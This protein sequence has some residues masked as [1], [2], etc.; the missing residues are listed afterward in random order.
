[1][2]FSSDHISGT[3]RAANGIARLAQ[4]RAKDAWQA[5]QECAQQNP[6]PMVLGALAIG[7]VVGVLCG[8]REPKPRDARRL[9]REFL[10]DAA[11]RL[12][13]RLHLDAAPG[14]LRDQ[15]ASLGRKWHGR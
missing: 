14:H 11:S 7:V 6:L 10:G 12:T 8:R 2:S 15:W 9:A 5:G 4:D 13:H 3:G 1:M